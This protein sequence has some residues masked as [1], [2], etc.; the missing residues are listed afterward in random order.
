[1]QIKKGGQ[2]YRVGNFDMPEGVVLAYDFLA[3]NFSASLHV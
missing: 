3:R 2:Q 1:M